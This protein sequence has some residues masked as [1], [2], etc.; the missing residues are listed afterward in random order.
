MKLIL[1]TAA[2][3]LIGTSALADESTRHNDLRLDTS[4]KDEQIFSDPMRP[5][6]LDSAQRGRD[7]RFTTAESD[8]R[9]DVSFSTRDDY[10]TKGEGYIYGGYGPGNDSR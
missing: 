5:T 1:T 2:V 9:P 10:R 8:P 3:A 6:D 7:Q 4:N